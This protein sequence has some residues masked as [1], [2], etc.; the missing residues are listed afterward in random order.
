V[1]GLDENAEDTAI[2]TAVTRLAQALGLH[3]IAEGVET[4]AQ[5][6]SLRDLGCEFGQGYVWSPP[7]PAAVLDAWLAR[8]TSDRSAG[9]APIITSRI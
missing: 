2:V 3:T 7:V 6:C 5:V 9:D 4:P 8:R 1:D